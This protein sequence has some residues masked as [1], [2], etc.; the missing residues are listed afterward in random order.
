MFRFEDYERLGNESELPGLLGA[1]DR[2]AEQSWQ[3]YTRENKE[4][5]AKVLERDLRTLIRQMALPATATSSTVSRP[6]NKD[7]YATTRSRQSLVELLVNDRLLVATSYDGHVWLRPCHDA[8]LR[9]WKRADQQI[10]VD[11]NHL[12]WRESLRQMAVHWQSAENRRKDHL[13]LPAASLA[14]ALSLHKEFGNDLN[15]SLIHI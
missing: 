10:A 11:L 3:N 13:D 4:K 12:R 14:G 6:I 7:L 15:L 8:L 9:H 1:I 5:K 2:Y